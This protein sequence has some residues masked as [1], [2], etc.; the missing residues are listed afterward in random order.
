MKS[1]KLGTVCETSEKS[2][3]LVGSAMMSMPSVYE[4]RRSSDV[5]QRPRSGGPYAGK[6][7]WIVNGV[8]ARGSK[9][10]VNMKCAAQATVCLARA[11]GLAP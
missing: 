3:L 4:N 5:S 6:S 2:G 8:R 1:R 10:A 11:T 7:V 9:H